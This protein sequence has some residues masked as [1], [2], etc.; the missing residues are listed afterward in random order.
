M[1]IQIV[2]P[3]DQYLYWLIGVNS[4]IYLSIFFDVRSV[5]TNSALLSSISYQ[6]PLFSE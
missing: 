2:F 4:K 6:L 5:C 1:L 3:R